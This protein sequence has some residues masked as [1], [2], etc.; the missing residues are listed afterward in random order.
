ME[1]HRAEQ[2]QYQDCCNM[3]IGRAAVEVPRAE[4]QVMQGGVRGRNKPAR[5]SEC[6]SCA[7]THAACL[8]EREV[9]LSIWKQLQVAEVGVGLP[10][11]LVQA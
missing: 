8:D 3:L 4:R 5:M 10:H 1:M 9:C 7:A 11:A 6:H 2:S